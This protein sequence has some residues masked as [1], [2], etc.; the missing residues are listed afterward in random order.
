MSQATDTHTYMHKAIIKQITLPQLLSLS[1]I[2]CLIRLS[3]APVVTAG[4]STTHKRQQN[5]ITSAMHGLKCNHYFG[6]NIFILTQ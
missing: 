6:S 1:I 2:H 5:H 3:A 4:V